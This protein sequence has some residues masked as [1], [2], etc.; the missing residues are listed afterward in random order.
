MATRGA[1]SLRG[2][3]RW[4][5]KLK[6]DFLSL[7]QYPLHEE[8]VKLA[9]VGPLLSLAG[10]FQYPFYPQAEAIPFG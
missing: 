4:L 10:L 2:R 3:L 7:E 9:M 5:D 8:L 6:T 1:G